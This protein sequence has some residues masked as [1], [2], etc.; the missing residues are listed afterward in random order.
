MVKCEDGC[1]LEHRDL[2]DL[3]NWISAP[4]KKGGVFAK[5]SGL[6]KIQWWITNALDSNGI[7]MCSILYNS[8]LTNNEVAKKKKK[9]LENVYVRKQMCI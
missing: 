6:F 7:N 9:E 8:F 4:I 3:N 2:F 5:F 1:F